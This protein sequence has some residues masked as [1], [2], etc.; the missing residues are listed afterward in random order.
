MTNGNTSREEIRNFLC[1]YFQNSPR[2]DAD[3]SNQKNDF[4]KAG[5]ESINFSYE[6][7]MSELW[8]MV[9]ERIIEPIW[10]GAYRGLNH[11]ILTRYGKELL[12]SLPIDCPNDYIDYLKSQ[13]PKIDSQVIVYV[14]ESLHSYNLQC[15]FAASVMLGV[16]AER[17][18]E[19]L[20]DAYTNAVQDPNA[21]RQFQQRTTGRGI[22]QQYAEFKKKLPD[23]IGSN[24]LTARF[25]DE[26]RHAIEITF[27]SIRSYRDYAAHPRNGVVPRHIIKGNL[28]A[29]PL[30]CSRLYQVIEFLRQNPV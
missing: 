8:D 1:K 22:N 10:Q 19:L 12:E 6:E 3:Q 21:K 14:R 13:V 25:R 7:I 5:L 18:F 4:K 11:F 23:L 17:L 9:M 2:L 29:F 24:R 30:F 15:Y 20:M 28:E 26:F 27:D 16:A